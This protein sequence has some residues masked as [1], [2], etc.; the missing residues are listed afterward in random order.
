MLKDSA[1][2]T[3]SNNASS[4]NENTADAAMSDEYAF[5]GTD[6]GQLSDDLFEESFDDY[7]KM[8]VPKMRVIHAEAPDRIFLRTQGKSCFFKRVNIQ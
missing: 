2:G 4:Q 5:M 8:L 3:W 7:E 1:L 6:C